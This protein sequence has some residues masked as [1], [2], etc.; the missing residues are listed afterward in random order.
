MKDRLNGLL[1]DTNNWIFVLVS[2][3]LGIIIHGQIVFNEYVWH[4]ETCMIFG[5]PNIRRLSEGRWMMALIMWIQERFIGKE[6]AGS[7]YAILG[8]F[9]TGITL[10]LIF[11]IL[12]IRS[13]FARIALLIVTLAS[14]SVLSSF[15]YMNSVGYCYAGI[16]FCTL[17]AVFI[18]YAVD[19]LEYKYTLLGALFFACG[20][21]TYQCYFSITTSLLILFLLKSVFLNE[22]DNKNIILVILK[23]GITELGALLLGLVTYLVVLG[24]SLE[25]FNVRLSNYDDINKFG[26]TSVW[27]YFQR[28]LSAY[29]EFFSFNRDRSYTFYPFRWKGW[30]ASAIFV[31]IASLALIIFSLIKA[32]KW[33]ELVTVLVLVI[34]FPLAVNFDF[35]LYPINYIH[36]IHV[37][38][39]VYIFYCIYLFISS[40]KGMGPKFEG[41][42]LLLGTIWILA[43]GILYYR[44]DAL[45]YTQLELNQEATINELNRLVMRIESTEGYKKEYPI[46]F[47]GSEYNMPNV[48]YNILSTSDNI[49]TNPY[50]CVI[51]RYSWESFMNLWINYYPE[52]VMLSDEEIEYYT[53]MDRPKYP[54]DGSVFIDDAMVIVNY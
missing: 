13:W 19:T 21:A 10:I 28:V 27:G 32:K 6:T 41:G 34:L 25:V 46:A 51:S 31:F 40:F 44:Y 39:S 11:D 37:Y 35:I 22:N 3:F 7:T 50:T 8:F 16:L 42:I 20:L 47:V 4:D 1:K 5:M 2:C 30:W 33:K 48:S 18:H 53:S 45:C 14:P 9:I 52:V 49:I 54:D 23:K 17:S 26:A 24:A 15:G 36:G 38:S 29:S 43:I 12:E